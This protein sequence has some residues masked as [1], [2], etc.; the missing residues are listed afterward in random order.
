MSGTEISFPEFQ[1][2]F[3]AYVRKDRGGLE[4]TR[5]QMAQSLIG[6]GKNGAE[7]MEPHDLAAV[8]SCWLGWDPQKNELVFRDEAMEKYFNGLKEEVQRMIL[9]Y[10]ARAFADEGSIRPYLFSSS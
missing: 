10:I 8:F 2:A 4:D 3:Q 7:L 9:V 1:M 6:L 5:E